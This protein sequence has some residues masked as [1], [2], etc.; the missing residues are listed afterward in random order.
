MKKFEGMLLCSDLDGTLLNSRH[1]V[2]K[3]NLDAIRY[4]QSEGGLFTFMTGRMP[5]C[6]TDLFETVRPNAPFGC[7]NGGGIYDGFSRKYLWTKPISREVLELVEAVDRQVPEAG[8]QIN[9][10]DRIWFS[11]ENSAMQRFRRITGSP[12]LVRGY[13]EVTEPIAK[14]VFGDEDPENI[15]SI[16]RLF[17][18][19]PLSDRFDYVSSERRLCELLPKNTNKGTV[20]MK[21]TELFGI[22]PRRT[23]ALGDYNNDVELLQAAG[24]GIAV[25]NATP[26]ALA[27]ADYVTVSNDDHAVAQTVADLESGRLRLP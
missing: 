10:F 8:I 19:H 27:A 20:L 7:I 4:F 23:V 14:I 12:N 13:R 11:K 22:D 3:E 18:A 5:Y 1:A 21:M 2:S 9:T 6:A 25:A 16:E 15:R 24:I 17:F 26:E